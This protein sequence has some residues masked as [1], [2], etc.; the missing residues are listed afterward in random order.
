MLCPIRGML[1]KCYGNSE[2][3]REV[4]AI[5]HCVGNVAIKMVHEGA[6]RNVKGM[7][8]EWWKLSGH[9]EVR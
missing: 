3:Q 6:E 4:T 7:L 9:R 2:K 1:G 8:G 5:W